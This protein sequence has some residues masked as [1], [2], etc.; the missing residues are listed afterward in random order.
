[1]SAVHHVHVTRRSRGL[2]GINDV[3]KPTT[4]TVDDLVAITISDTKNTLNG[5]VH[6]QGVVIQ[7]LLL[8]GDQLTATVGPRVETLTV[9][10]DHGVVVD[11]PEVV[12]LLRVDGCVTRYDVASLTV[13]ATYLHAVSEAVS[14][15]LL[16]VTPR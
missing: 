11:L 2:N 1:N 5:T 13:D 7:G 14:V 3:L 6:N 15:T 16:V 8:V 10:V 12:A 9:L 4:L